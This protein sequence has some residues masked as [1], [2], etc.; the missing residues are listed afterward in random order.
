MIQLVVAFYPEDEGNLAYFS[1]RRIQLMLD[2]LSQYLDREKRSDLVNRLNDKRVEQSLPAEAELAVLWMLKDF[3]AFEIEPFWWAGGKKP[4]AYVEGLIPGM[5]AVV[6]VTAISDNSMSGEKDMDYCARELMRVADSA[7]R[8]SGDYLHF[9][10]AESR[11]RE[12]NVS[13]REIAAPKNFTP[14]E[15]TIILIRDW[16]LCGKS[17]SQPL[18]ISDGGLNVK[19][20]R[21]KVKLTRYHNIHTSRPPRV[22]S[23]VD[24]PIYRSLCQKL[25]QVEGAGKGIWKVIVLFDAGSRMLS[26]LAEDNRLGGFEQHST[27]KSIINRFIR[28]KEG[29]VDAVLAIVPIK[30]FEPVVFSANRFERKWRAICFGMENRENLALLQSLAG[31]INMFPPPIHSGV[32]A[33]NL[34]RGKALSHKSRGWYLPTT[35]SGIG[36]DLKFKTS[37]RVFQDFLARRISENDFRRYLGD[38]DGAF[39]LKSYFDGGYAIKM[40]SFE[41]GGVDND[42]D[43]IIFELSQDPS[44]AQYK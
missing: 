22:Y 1:R 26:D 4:D 27:A 14:S 5:P 6:E 38:G 31:L 44:N 9:S 18:A 39:D 25:A 7:E 3:E 8:G 37:V 33:R 35:I 43:Y 34:T 28:D 17:L 16:L 2:E 23:D 41:P 29:R 15:D 11:R 21:R 30:K 42:D 20:E 24:N 10:F 40:V 19:I 36:G 13:I 12:R 32:N